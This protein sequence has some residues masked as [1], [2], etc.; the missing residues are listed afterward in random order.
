MEHFP[1]TD[2]SLI[3]Q[4]Q[5]GADPAAWA[6]FSAVYRPVVYRLARH[7]GLQDADAEDL[8][9]QVFASIAKAI[10][11]W[12]PGP[13]KPPFRAWLL[14]V[15]RN[16]IVKAVTRARPDVGAGSTSVQEMLLAIPKDDES[17]VTAELLKQA[18]YEAFRWAADQVRHE[19]TPETWD[20]FWSTTVLGDKVK[21]VAARQNKSTGA[22]YMARFRVMQR[23][24]EKVLEVTL[25]GMDHQ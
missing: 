10:M 3:L 5:T 14:T 8:V 21:N 17:Q 12:E 19:F 1:E 25:D 7:R 11:R 9:Q 15:A 18:R 23:L 22:V 16:A 4:V 6:K 2:K 13:N 20:M 24:K